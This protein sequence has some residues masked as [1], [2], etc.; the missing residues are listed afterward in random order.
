MAQYYDKIKDAPLPEFPV[1][2]G[3]VPGRSGELIVL[4]TTT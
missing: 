4:D 3:E 2:W 1:K